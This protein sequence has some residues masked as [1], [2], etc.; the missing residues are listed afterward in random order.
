MKSVFPNA[1]F[2]SLFI[3]NHLVL[4]GCTILS[5]LGF[6]VFESLNVAAIFPVM[7]SI[8]TVTQPPGDNGRVIHFVNRIVSY[9]PLQDLFISS[10][11]LL[12]GATFFKSMSFLLFN[13]VSNKLSQICRR[14]LQNQIYE[15]FLY[16]DY[17]YFLDNKQGTLLYR[18]LNAPSHVGTALKLI[19]DIFIQSIK[20]LFLII[21]LFTMSARAATGMLVVGVV[22]GILIKSL[23]RK[24]YRFGKE[25]TQALTDETTI[26]NE[27]VSGIRQIMIFSNQKMWIRRFWGK[28]NAYYHYKLRSQILNATP[29]I[30]LEPIVISAV[31]CI[32]MLIK[33]RYGNQF[34]EVLPMLS[35]YAL[36]IFRINPS[37]S[38]IGQHRMLMMNILPNIEI[39]YSTLV[40]NTRSLQNGQRKLHSFQK[41][42]SFENVAFHYPNRGNVFKELS[43]VI[44]KGE[45]IAIVGPSGAGKSTL[46][47]LLVR[48]YDPTHGNIKVDKIGLKD[49]KIDTWRNKIGYV[50]QDPFIFH[51]TIDENISFAENKYSEEE[52][53]AAAR[54]AN[55]HEFI[56]EFPDGYQTVVGDKGMKL[57]GGQKQR[58]TIAR[59]IIRKPELIIFDEATSSLD[60]ISENLVQKAIDEISKKYTVI[61]IAHRLST[62]Q[63]ADRIIVLDNKRIAEEGKHSELLSFKG[64]YWAL[65]NQATTNYN[66]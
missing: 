35:V 61:I 48:L 42:I 20:I 25:V 43:L 26:A 10:C 2:L 41:Q 63:N 15:K 62:I 12:I 37:L 28:I 6:A 4:V 36:A 50:S 39:C 27:S 13:Y 8:L 55:A 57:S 5:G 51:A 31:A 30:I 16:S 40:A 58:I 46:M 14:D 54:N 33:V 3:R 1:R 17:Q 66:G 38:I 19:P 49:I 21:L 65:Y 45:T 23:S 44:N 64:V 52:I 11:V 7:N 34:I 47:D 53:I 32:G 56:C 29:V 18:L 60:T 22:F 59:A 9:F 24:T